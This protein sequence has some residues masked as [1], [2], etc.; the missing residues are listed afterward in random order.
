MIRRCAITCI[1]F[2]ALAAPS[3]AEDFSVLVKVGLK[4][5]E[6]TD[7]SGKVTLDGGTIA[8]VTGWRLTG[9]DEVGADGTWSLTTDA[10]PQTKKPQ[11]T[12][13]GIIV[14][15]D[16]QAGALLHLTVGD[17]T[18]DV[19]LSGLAFGAPSV[20][21]SRKFSA[22][23]APRYHVLS[24]ETGEDDYPA[25]CA[26]PDGGIFAVWQSFDGTEDKLLWATMEDGAWSKAQPIPRLTGDLY[27]P[28]CAADSSGAVL[29]T[30]PR[31]VNDTYTLQAVRLTGGKWSKPTGISTGAGHSFNQAMS[32]DTAGNVYCAWQQYQGASSDI[33]LAVCN[34]GKWDKPQVVA[35]SPGNEWSPCLASGAAGTWV[36]WDT[37]MNGSYDIYAAPIVDGEPEDA[38]AIA[39]SPRFEAKASVACDDAG[40]VWIAWQDAGENWGK[41]TGYTVPKDQPNQALYRE[42]NVKVACIEAG[43]LK[44]APA[45]D[46]VTPDG[47]S[48]MKEEP[49]LAADASGRV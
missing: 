10:V 40:R 27:Q 6:P 30:C 25:A 16:A 18:W 47:Q 28:K 14:S 29:V 46:I 21:D 12:P 2:I 34:D 36:A 38:V 37:Y 31:F 26:L 22:Q 49:R 23:L 42:R 15:G 4:D 32:A 33:L 43:Q 11:T 8:D 9:K 39:A 19:A 35:D 1:A 24:G 17:V 41:D 5:T 44:A 45:F 13:G 48:G 20:H 7:W 3:F